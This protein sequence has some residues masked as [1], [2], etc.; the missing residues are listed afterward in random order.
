MPNYDSRTG[1]SNFG[2]I[3]VSS[4]N[5]AQIFPNIKPSYAYEQR[6]SRSDLYKQKT[7]QQISREIPSKFI[8]P[9]TNSFLHSRFETQ[10]SGIYKCCGISIVSNLTAISF[11]ISTQ[12]NSTQRGFMD[13]GVLNI[14]M[15][16]S[17]CQVTQLYTCT[18]IIIHLIHVLIYRR[19]RS[20]QP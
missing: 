17:F 7:S 10:N 20:G 6:Y 2:N 1:P 19:F 18:N 13:A 9:V 3:T 8:Y 16:T 15:S 4:P 12:L 14:S 5:W 11:G